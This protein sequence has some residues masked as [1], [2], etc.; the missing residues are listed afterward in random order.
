MNKRT[1]LRIVYALATPSILAGCAVGG[2]YEVANVT[3][4]ALRGAAP[5]T[6]MKQ[7][8]TYLERSLRDPES[9]KIR[10]LTGPIASEDKSQQ[11]LSSPDPWFGGKGQ[12]AVAVEE[13]WL[14][15]VE[16][17]SKNGYGGYTGY[18]LY[19]FRFRGE[20]LI[21]ATNVTD[22]RRKADEAYQRFMHSR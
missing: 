21:S 2:S 10:D 18:E 4:T 12:L 7:V 1:F 17:N 14:V 20:D 8:T 15:T 9:M 13:V 16:V 22:Q 11:E 3:T 6:W 5:T 19:T